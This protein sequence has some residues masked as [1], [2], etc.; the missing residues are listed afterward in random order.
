MTQLPF[1]LLPGWGLGSGPFSSL[2]AHF[3]QIQC[4]DLP[5][6]GNRPLVENFDLA[7]EETLNSLP[8]QVILAGWSL[9]TML[10]LACA[11]RRP[12]KIARLVLI[13]GTPCFV[14]RENW[15]HGMPPQQLAEFT[16]AFA[17][18]YETMLRRFV[19]GF[20]RGDQHAKSVTRNLLDTASPKASGDT[21]AAGLQWLAEVDLRPSLP[22][23]QAPT[24]MIHGAHD[25]LMP[26]AGA[27]WTAA[28]IPGARLEVFEQAAHAPF[29]SDPE[30]FAQLVGLT[31]AN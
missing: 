4:L 14:Q 11:A 12:D 26:L 13:A 2:Q 15:P 7:V 22:S 10:A 20:N 8:N 18:D 24:L 6:Y 9:G 5:G 19:G 25:P 29:V 23:I 31:L 17:Q 27:Q 21:L 1:V 16:A 28:Q 3:P 30:R